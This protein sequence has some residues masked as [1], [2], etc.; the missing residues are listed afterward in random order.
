M[1][2]ENEIQTEGVKQARARGYTV[3]VMSAPFRVLKQFRG[4]PDVF[5]FAPNVLQMLETKSK[6]GKLRDSQLEFFEA[7]K[8]FLGPNLRYSVPRSTAEIMIILAQLPP[9]W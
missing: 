7:V 5:I 9:A 1:G 2:A 4:I 6:D 3:R 8:P